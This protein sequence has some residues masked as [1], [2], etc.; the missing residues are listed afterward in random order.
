M[1][2]SAM[3]EAEGNLLIVAWS[4]AIALGVFLLMAG[5]TAVRATNRGA[6]PMLGVLVTAIAVTVLASVSSFLLLVNY[7]AVDSQFGWVLGPYRPVNQV[8][9]FAALAVTALFAVSTSQLKRT[10]K[11]VVIRRPGEDRVSLGEPLGEQA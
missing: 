5:L 3:S 6:A 4:A 10:P 11:P 9:V 2:L 7:G 1:V 8:T